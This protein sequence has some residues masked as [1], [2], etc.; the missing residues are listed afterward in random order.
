METFFSFISILLAVLFPYFL[1]TAIR[2]QDE[3]KSAVY[4]RLS[5]LASG[6]ILFTLIGLH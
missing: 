4:I 5:C 1:V 2:A 6:V 3:N